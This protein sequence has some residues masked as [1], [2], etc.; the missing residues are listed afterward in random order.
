ML[1]I[2]LLFLLFF[3]NVFAYEESFDEKN[4]YFSSDNFRVIVGIEY[5][6]DE[7]IENLASK[8]LN[9]AQ[10]TWQKEII[11]LGFKKPRNSDT[12][13]IDIYIGNKK[14]YNSNTQ[15]YETISSGYAGWA[16]SYTDNTPYFLINP[17]I[18]DN[19]LKVTISHEFF[20]TIQY[21]YFDETQI[22]DDKWFKNI[23]WLEATA[24]LMEDE[25]YDDINDYT[26][27]LSAFFNYSYK[28]IEIYDGSHE[29]STVIFA[30]YI[31]EKYGLNI[32]KESLSII[33]TSDDD[34]FF[35]ILDDLLQKYYQSSMQL[36]LNEFANWVLYKD[37][38]F[39]EGSLYPSITTYSIS[40]NKSIEKGGI[41]VLNDIMPNAIA[42]YKVSRDYKAFE[43]NSNI[44][45]E[46]ISSL[47]S[48]WTLIGTDSNISDLSILDNA[49]LVW[50]YDANT[51][52][53][54]SSNQEYKDAISLTN[55]PTIETIKE[56]S[57][58]WILK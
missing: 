32:I 48:G 15:Q 41:L 44:T 23:W 46:Y 42:T 26:N 50:Q 35:E 24:T 20:H 39:E 49:T 8:L 54:Y 30:K 28:S 57:G 56:N 18:S 9:Y 22:A 25:V 14:A 2:N 11:D 36:A 33:E 43:K 53:A 38:Y 51:W 13:K 10:T 47:D 34:G 6:N 4:I 5:Q 31:K 3:I 52:K 21:A 27:Y 29:Y 12:K 1:K 55:T 40:Q 45:Q 17:T 37:E 19:L 16:T 58:I 7:E